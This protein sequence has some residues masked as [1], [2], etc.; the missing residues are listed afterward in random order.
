MTLR[1]RVLEK[2]IV[3]QLVKKLSAIMKRKEP[4]TRLQEPDTRH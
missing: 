2:V 1:R 4:L 3:A